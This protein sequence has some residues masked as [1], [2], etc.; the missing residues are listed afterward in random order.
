MA[1][2]NTLAALLSSPTLAL[3]R[4]V[5]DGARCP[6]GCGGTWNKT[7]GG[8]V[9]EK[10]TIWMSCARQNGSAVGGGITEQCHAVCAILEA[11]DRLDV[12][13]DD[14]IETRPHV[15]VG[16]PTHAYVGPLAI[17]VEREL[18]ES[19]NTAISEDGYWH[20]RQLYRRDLTPNNIIG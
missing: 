16:S 14:A 13:P 11:C 8:T 15:Q 1:K 19:R 5:Y 20:S 7:V 6:C 12:S 10:Q 17:A 3:M 18:Y 2:I 9:A 4:A